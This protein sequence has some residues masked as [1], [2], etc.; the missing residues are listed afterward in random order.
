MTD[1]GEV[2][3]GASHREFPKQFQQRFVQLSE[4]IYPLN[5]VESIRQASYN[6]IIV[7]YDHPANQSDLPAVKKRFESIQLA[8]S[9]TQVKVAHEIIPPIQ[10]QWI[11][12][13]LRV[14]EE[15]K[16]TG[17]VNG[18]IPKQN[19]EQYRQQLLRNHAE[20]LALWLLDNGFNVIPLEHPDVQEWIRQ[21]STHFPVEEENF[22]GATQ[23]IGREFFTAIKRDIH[24]LEVMDRERPDVVSAGTAHA[25]KLDLLLGRSGNSSFYFLQNPINW[26]NLLA[27]WEQAHNLYRRLKFA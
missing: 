21:D 5:V 7:G 25:I 13:F 18:E 12:D 6:P 20:H 10:L 27:E 23:P 3:H 14:E 1:P 8:R 17:S 26:E 9:G 22:S 19:P 2:P 24:S 16:K 11:K 15:F 4:G